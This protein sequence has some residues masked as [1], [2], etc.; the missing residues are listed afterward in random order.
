MKPKSSLEER[1]DGWYV[2]PIKLLKDGLPEGDGSLLAL[3]AVLFLY[4]RYYRVLTI[5]YD[6]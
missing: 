1:F 2:K 4:E 3:S 6:K 5:T